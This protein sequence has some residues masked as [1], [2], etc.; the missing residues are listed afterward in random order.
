MY[1]STPYRIRN[2]LV[3]TSTALYTV[4]TAS[5]H[6]ARRGS[7]WLCHIFTYGKHMQT[8]CRIRIFPFL[9]T[10]RIRSGSLSQPHLGRVQIKATDDSPKQVP[11]RCGDEQDPSGSEQS[12]C[13]ISKCTYPILQNPESFAWI[14]LLCPRGAAAG[15]S[16]EGRYLSDRLFISSLC[17][18]LFKST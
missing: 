18:S 1:V 9:H 6:L 17:S 2:R 5:V 15:S 7:F 3:D 11:D 12:H 4:I 14:L 10:H 16:R 13:L 8:S